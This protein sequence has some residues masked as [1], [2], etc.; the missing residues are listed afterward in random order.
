V[1]PERARRRVRFVQADLQRLSSAVCMA[2]VELERPEA[3]G[4]VGTAVAPE[5]EGL[6]ATARA[7]ADALMQAVADD[8]VLE[9]QDIKLLNVLGRLAVVVHLGARRQEDWR[10]LMG[11]CVAGQDPTRAAALAVLHATNRVL[12]VG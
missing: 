1:T 2:R 12:N 4:Y 5:A 6:R 11:F 10:S 3:G 7:A 9:V 8:H